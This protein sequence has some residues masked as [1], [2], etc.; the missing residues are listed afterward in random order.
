[1]EV[2]VPEQAVHVRWSADSLSRG[3][4]RL[5]IVA[6]HHMEEGGVL[7][8]GLVRADAGDPQIRVTSP[9]RAMPVSELLAVVGGFAATDVEGEDSVDVSVRQGVSRVRNRWV[10]ARTGSRGTTFDVVLPAAVSVSS[11][12][13]DP[14]LSL[15]GEKY[16]RR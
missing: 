4:S 13:Q 9:G 5:L 15:S 7:D 2:T 6:M 8:V 14:V 10:T 3:L 12:Q 16:G 1:M 11:D